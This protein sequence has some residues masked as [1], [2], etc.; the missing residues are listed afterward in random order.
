MKKLYVVAN[1]EGRG[2]TFME[3][4]VREETETEYEVDTSL[5]NVLWNTGTRFPKDKINVNLENGFVTDDINNKQLKKNLLRIYNYLDE[6]HKDCIKRHT[7]EKEVNDKWY[8]LA[9][10]E[11]KRIQKES[12]KKVI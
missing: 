9:L 8:N 3:V 4:K 5:N 7:M 1:Y 6:D 2:V 11:I 10:E 12:K